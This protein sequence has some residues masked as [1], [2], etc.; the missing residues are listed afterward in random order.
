MYFKDS[1]RFSDKYD[2]D[3]CRS[4]SY[5]LVHFKA[6][7]PR[8]KNI[9]PLESMFSVYPTRSRATPCLKCVRGYMVFLLEVKLGETLYRG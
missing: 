4:V 1:Y 8:E 6:I 7:V 3:R 5:F 9:R 2:T